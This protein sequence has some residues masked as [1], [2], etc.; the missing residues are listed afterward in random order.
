MSVVILYVLGHIGALTV[1]WQV[2]PGWHCSMERTVKELINKKRL[3]GTLLLGLQLPGC[4]AM[5]APAEP[6]GYDSLGELA[7]AGYLEMAEQFQG[8]F[9][10]EDVTVA[11]GVERRLEELAMKYA[12]LTRLELMEQVQ[13]KLAKEQAHLAKGRLGQLRD[14]EGSIEAQEKR[15]I[16]VEEEAGARQ[17]VEKMEESLQ[18]VQE[19]L[20]IVQ[21]NMRNKVGRDA[22]AAI[23]DRR[24]TGEMLRLAERRL[25]RAK[26]KAVSAE[27]MMVRHAIGGDNR[28][29]VMKPLRE[30]NEKLQADLE[31]AARKYAMALMGAQEQENDISQ[32]DD[33]KCEETFANPE[34]KADHTK[35][36][37]DEALGVGSYFDEISA[38]W[39]LD[40]NLPLRKVPDQ[41]LRLDLE[42]RLD[43]SHTDGVHGSGARSRARARLYP[44][45]NIDGNWHAKGMMEW[46]KV[47]S[48]DKG[49]NDGKVRLSRYY[50]SGNIGVIHTDVGVF[51]SN[52]A[53]GNIYDSKYRGVRFSA[54][55]PVRYTFEAGKADQEEVRNSWDFTAS[56]KG[57]DY[58]IDGGFYRFG[59]KN[60]SW[61]NV[62]VANYTHA[63]GILDASAMALYGKQSGKSGKAGVV[64]TLGYTP[65]RSWRPYVWTGWVKYYYQPSST[66]LAHTMNGKADLMKVHGGFKGWGAGIS[67]NLPDDWNIGLEYYALKDL[68]YGHHANTVWFVLTKSFKNYDD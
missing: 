34:E 30:K 3:L 31:I 4:L 60:G 11:D 18:Q 5:A 42:L 52:M 56:Y 29:E 37:I 20:R 63:I 23:S 61:Q 62:Y 38:A 48:G 6:W 44:D 2:C 1:R 45:Y 19:S 10:H 68:D 54:G 39:H 64:L 24:H 32:R 51:S 28:L 22:S 27:E 21:E 50:L 16:F 65:P 43:T 15:R 9:S 40:P 26:R 67:Y 12:F 8:N 33:K 14:H 35:R 17:R 66:Y 36:E 25:E 59:F 55:K 13:L 47:F 7:A 46:E 49:R 57:V 41:R 58:G 53:E